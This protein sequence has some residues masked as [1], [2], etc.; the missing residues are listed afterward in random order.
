[1]NHSPIRGNSIYSND[2]LFGGVRGIGIDLAGDGVTLNDLGDADT[3]S[4]DRQN[5]PIIASAIPSGGNTTVVGTLNSLANTT[6]TIDFYVNQVCLSRPQGFREGQEYLGATEVTTDGSGNATIDVVLPVPIGPGS[7]VTATATSPEGNTSE[8]SQRLVLSSTPG[9]GSAAGGTPIVLTGFNFLAG[10]VVTVG[11]TPA[12]S[13]VVSNYNQITANTPALEPGSLSGITVTNT[14]GSAGTLPNGWIADFIDVPG[15]QQFHEF[16]T[17]LVRNSITVGVGQGLYGVAQPTLR[18]QMAVFL[19]RAKYGLCYTPP[20]CT[21]VFPDVPC[22]SNFAPWIEALCG[23]GDHQRL[24]GRKLLSRQPRHAPADGRLPAE[25]RTRIDVRAPG[26]HRRLHRRRLPFAI[27]R[28]DRA[29]GRR[30]DHRGLRRYEL[31]SRQPGQSG[32]NGRFP[33]KDVRAS[34]RRLA[35]ERIAASTPAPSQRRSTPWPQARVRVRGEVDE[36][37]SFSVAT[38]GAKKLQNP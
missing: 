12:T 32:T 11:A 36:S 38:E 19:L 23:R 35:R 34:V 18:Q 14:D 4:N 29:A 25:N 15:G 7:P 24:R 37:A 26:L 2:A 10:A 28:L 5:F 1:M 33:G 3:G 13:V 9:G 20:P 16:V 22:P 6:F 31:L 21:G 8:F 17:T 30:G 27:R